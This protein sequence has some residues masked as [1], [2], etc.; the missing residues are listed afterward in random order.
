MIFIYYFYIYILFVGFFLHSFSFQVNQGGI[1]WPLVPPNG[2][3]DSAWFGS[4][5]M[6][7]KE[8]WNK[9]ND[10]VIL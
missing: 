3:E 7:E 10:T 1:P 6:R 9:W 5:S 8:V 2:L 4:L